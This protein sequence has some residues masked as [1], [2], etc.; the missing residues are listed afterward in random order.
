VKIRAKNNA[1]AYIRVSTEEQARDAFGLES[2]EKACRQL[3][4]E[5]GWTLRE[6]FKDAGVSGWADVERPGF[7][8]MMRSIQNDRDVNLVFYD[9]S[10]FGRKT[11]SA[12]KAFENWTA[13]VCS[14]S[15]PQILAS[16]V[17]RRQAEQRGVMN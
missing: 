9:Y 15:P 11:L 17:G 14:Q 6:I 10:R 4:A 13:W 2:Q 16:T 8:G 7:Q 1:V 12:L 5:R 3:C